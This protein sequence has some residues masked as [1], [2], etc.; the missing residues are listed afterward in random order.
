[1]IYHVLPILD[2]NVFFYIS[3]KKYVGVAYY[4]LT[5]IK[6]VWLARVVQVF[7]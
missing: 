3:A 1:L 4:Y 6:S 5:K 2:L 7:D